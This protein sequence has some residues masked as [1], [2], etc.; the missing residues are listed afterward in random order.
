MPPTR[1]T[2][3]LKVHFPD[4]LSSPESLTNEI[5]ITAHTSSFEIKERAE[6]PRRQITLD[7]LAVQICS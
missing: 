7:V 3:L 5:L 1:V 4:L 6:L 2:Y